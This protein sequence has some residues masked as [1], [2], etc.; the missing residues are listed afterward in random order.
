LWT[1]QMSPGRY[2]DEDVRN[3][4]KLF[5]L[6]AADYWSLFSVYS[7]SSSLYRTSNQP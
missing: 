3:W 4:H 1:I 2:V 5:S 7:S 6:R